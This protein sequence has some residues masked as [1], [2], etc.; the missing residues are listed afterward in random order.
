[1]S[2]QLTSQINNNVIPNLDYFVEWGG[3]TWKRQLNYA[4]REFTGIDFAGKK[5]LEIGS[6]S[7]KMACLF[8]RLG[9]TVTG[10]DINPD[11][12]GNAVAEAINMEVEQRTN[13]IAY[14]GDFD[15]FPDE[16]FDLI[17]TKSVL[18]IVPELECFLRQISNKLK[19]SGK[20]LFLENAK[21]GLLHKLR[22]FR[23]RTWNYQKAKFFTDKELNL[24]CD[25][26]QV[27]EIKK[28]IFPPT[29]LIMGEKRDKL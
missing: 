19:P 25:I 1:L 26:F 28:T 27:F 8:A 22:R 20:V 14:N 15:I 29:Y 21:G 17:F 7:G 9:G 10:I 24:I 3:S 12:I 13:F 4:L 6:R 18:V 5:I 16:S 2:E 23:H 11:F